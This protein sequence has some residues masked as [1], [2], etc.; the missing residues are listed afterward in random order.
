MQVLKSPPKI[1]VFTTRNEPFVGSTPALVNTGGFP[2]EKLG[3]IQYI[4]QKLTQMKA[5]FILL[6]LALA[7]SQCRQSL[8]DRIQSL[9][10]ENQELAAKL[11]STVKDLVSLR[12]SINIQGRALTPDEITFTGMVN[13]VEYTY[14]EVQQNLGTLQSMPSDSTRL[15]KELSL[16]T[17]LTELM[18]R[19]DSILQNRN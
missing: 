6:T 9:H 4:C 16:N 13:E 15:E 14:R 5:V 3:F 7:M 10:Q 17:V 1:L 12:N 18:S 19:A 11:D 2:S 8:D